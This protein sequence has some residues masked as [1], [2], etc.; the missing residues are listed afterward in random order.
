[1]VL[2]EITADYGTV[3]EP[4]RSIEFE[5]LLEKLVVSLKNCIIISKP[6]I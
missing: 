5:E 6:L 1:L 3:A 2:R 4:S